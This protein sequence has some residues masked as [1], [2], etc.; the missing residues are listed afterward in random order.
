MQRVCLSG[1]WRATDQVGLQARAGRTDFTDAGWVPISVPGHWRDTPEWRFHS[2]KLLYRRT[3]DLPGPVAPGTAARLRL[4]GVFYYTKIWLNGRFVGEQEGYFMPHVHDVSRWLTVGENVLLLEVDSPDEANRLKKRQITGIW[5]HWDCREPG[6]NPGGI[7]RD[8]WLE[9]YPAGLLPGHLRVDAAPQ[10][11]PAPPGTPPNPPRLVGEGEPLPATV[12][13]SLEFQAAAEGTM[14]WTAE[15]LPETFAGAAASAAGT[16]HY[17]RGLGRLQA[18]I[19]LHDCRLW[20]SWDH[21]APDLYR[22]RLTLRPAGGGEP[23]ALER[24]FGVRE[25]RMANWHLHLNGRRVFLRGTNY[26]PPDIRIAGCTRPDYARDLAL[27]REAGMNTVRV[28]AHVD[29]PELY[30]EADRQGILLWQDFPLQ[31]RYDLSIIPEARRQVRE[32]VHLLGSH[33]SVVI[34]CCHNEPIRLLETDHPSAGHFLG[35]LA[36]LF[37]P[38]RNRF[39]L[40]AALGRAVRQADGTRPVWESSGEWGIL[41]GGTDTHPYWGWYIGGLDDFD[42]VTALRPRIMRLV[43][44]YGSQSFP[45][46]ENVARIAGGTWPDLDWEELDHRYMLQPVLMER[47][48]PRHRYG[49]LAEYAA[50]THAYQAL[51][52]RRY[53]ERLRMHKYRPCGGALQFMFSDCSPGVSWALA[54][55]WRGLK[56]AY[57]AA[58]HAFRPVQIMAPWPRARWRRG[59][60]VQHPVHLVNDTYRQLRGNWTWQVRR[61]G[62]VLAGGGGPVAVPP[63]ANL[64]L[65]GVRWDVPADLPPGPAELVLA[66]DLDGEPP[67]QASYPVEW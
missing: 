40:D 36:S 44:E 57:A 15:A 10:A 47:R 53:T 46:A 60:L 45:A 2:G 48:V 25:V 7:W 37:L 17:R 14:E 58:Q 61:D 31:W 34:W 32:M 1:L 30:E 22:L 50:A 20:W 24:C 66:F 56:P 27:V 52:L 62:A 65:D 11:L 6:F 55:Y 51:V 21:G 33:P 3:F 8:V 49:S 59:V 39:M 54:D 42:R 4:D 23:L 28:H 63:D 5:G 19:R 29:R 64:V 13:V 41:A 43:S 18:E 67:G 9:F 12:K 35:V 16:L 38:N 26:P